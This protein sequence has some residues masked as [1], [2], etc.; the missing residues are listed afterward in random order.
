MSAPWLFGVPDGPPVE[1]VFGPVN[2]CPPSVDELKAIGEL[3]EAPW[4]FVC[5]TYTSPA[6]GLAAEVFVSTS[7][8][9]LSVNVPAKPMTPGTANP[10]A[11]RSTTVVPA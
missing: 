1:I 7:I 5:A 4:K 9:S 11:P 10:T 3:P 6:H 2:V 8:H